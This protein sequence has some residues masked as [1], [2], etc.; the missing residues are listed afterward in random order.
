MGKHTV[1]IEFNGDEP[2]YSAN[3]EA[4]GGR[5]VA[6]AFADE[7]ERCEKI[8]SQRDELLEALVGLVDDVCERND[9]EDSSTNPGIKYAVEAARAAIAKAR[10]EA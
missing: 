10:G 8:E 1:V 7:L 2:A 3:M 9:M 6:V 5:V 4:L